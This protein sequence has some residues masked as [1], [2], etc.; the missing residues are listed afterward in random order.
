MTNKLDKI[1]REILIRIMYGERLVD[2][3]K[4][5]NLIH[6]TQLIRRIVRIQALCFKPTTTSACVSIALGADTIEDAVDTFIKNH[7]GSSL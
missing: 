2:I 7:G 3:S 6:K 5:M 4:S 1:D